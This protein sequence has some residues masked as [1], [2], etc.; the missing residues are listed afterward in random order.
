MKMKAKVGPAG[1]SVT[2]HETEKP[3]PLSVPIRSRSRRRRLA[4]VMCTST[5]GGSS[6]GWSTRGSLNT[7]GSMAGSPAEIESVSFQSFQM[8]DISMR[9][10]ISGVESLTLNRILILLPRR[11]KQRR[12]VQIRQRWCSAAE[13]RDA[14]FRVLACGA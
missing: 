5:N 6:C 3:E 1:R 13:D 8:K 4:E 12:S 11:E 7:T 9:I 10:K 14:L 2:L